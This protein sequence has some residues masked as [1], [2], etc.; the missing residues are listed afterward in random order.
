MAGERWGNYELEECIGS[1][2]MAEVFRAH[3]LGVSTFRREV[4]LKR[5][6]KRERESADFRALFL[7]E[8]KLG[9]KLN[10]KNIVRIEDCDE[11]EGQCFIAM[12]FVNGE[13][14][15]DVLRALR[16]AAVAMPVDAG[17]FIAHELLSALAYA[18]T[19]RVAGKPLRIVHRDVSP[20]NVMVSYSGEVKLMDF[21][22]AKSAQQDHR[23]E[24][25]S[26]RGKLAYM[27]YEQLDGRTV[28]ARSDL[29]AVGITLFEMFSSELPFS[30]HP[31]PAMFEA[32][33]NDDH[34]SLGAL[35]PD[36]PDELIAL[37][38]RLFLH[39]PARRPADADEARDV[40]TTLPG[41]ATGGRALQRLMASLFPDSGSI[42]RID[43]ARIVPTAP[44]ATVR[45]IDPYAATQSR[46]S[47]L[48]MPDEPTSP[49]I[50]DDRP[51]ARGTLPPVEAR[52]GLAAFPLWVAALVAAAALGSTAAALAWRQRT[53]GNA[54]TAATA[55]AG[56]S[57]GAPPITPAFAIP[58]NAASANTA[59]E[60]QTA[61]DPPVAPP[62]NSLPVH[63]SATR[64]R[65][66]VR[67]APIPQASLAASAPEHP[68]TTAPQ[69]APEPVPP[70]AEVPAPAPVAMGSI[71]VVAL[72]WG[73]VIIDGV[74]HGRSPVS[75]RVPAGEHQVRITGGVEHTERVVVTAGSTRT[76]HAEAE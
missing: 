31:L 32:K 49:P 26:A 12:E 10:H 14:L 60:P 35:R 61:L 67:T 69:P 2:G 19:F 68:P 52:R 21:G 65:N 30:P 56:L 71:R 5:I 47:L 57:P 64:D 18:H 9:E 62:T 37:V 1:G 40:I 45:S 43:R 7:D 59:S 55:R 13:N 44:L 24:T 66:A 27:P 63:V 28:D 29:Y 51:T 48:V 11:H 73:E 25:G 50:A 20:H 23:T 36:L 72:P 33:R 17:L 34:P 74:S 53:T 76:V 38:D 22:I 70:V 6:I 3:R 8:A 15:S 75:I 16:S 39:D 54:D 41:F 42:A 58:A 46:P 4:C